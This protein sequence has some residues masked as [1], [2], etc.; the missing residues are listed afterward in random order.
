MKDINQDGYS[1]L[2][3]S[4]SDKNSPYNVRLLV[5]Y[6]QNSSTSPLQ[7][8]YSLTFNTNQ[9]ESFSDLQVA[10]MDGDG[11][12]DLVVFIEEDSSGGDIDE[13]RIYHNTQSTGNSS[14]NTSNYT[15]IHMDTIFGADIQEVWDIDLIDVDGDGDMDMFLGLQ[16]GNVWQD[17]AILTQES[18][19]SFSVND[20]ATYD[21]I[22]AG[23]MT[24]ATLTNIMILTAMASLIISAQCAIRMARVPMALTRASTGDGSPPSLVTSSIR[25]MK[26]SPLPLAMQPLPVTPLLS[27]ITA[28]KSAP[29][30]RPL[31]ISPMAQWISPSIMSKTSITAAETC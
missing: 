9:N 22:Y 29:Q 13:L 5:T 31:P 20:Y 25:T 6:G 23:S 15:A 11:W 26:S 1:D 2:I 14:F 24:R 12:E 27:P 30:P 10:D 18:D 8:G 16:R 7:Q 21:R 19:G 3:Y 17:F 4:A 28:T